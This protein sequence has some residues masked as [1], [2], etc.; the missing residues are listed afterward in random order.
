LRFRYSTEDNGRL[1]KKA[2]VYTQDEHR[3]NFSD[4]DNQAVYIIERLQ[5]NGYETYIVGGAVRDLILGKKPKDFDIVTEASPA[6]IKRVFRNSRIIGRRFR[7]VHVFFGAKIFEVSTF[8]SLKDGP[9]SNTFG[10]VD[11]DV[12]RRDFSLNALFYDPLKQIVVDYVGGMKDIRKRLIRPIIPLAHIFTDDPVRMIRAVK[13]G[14]VTGFKLPLSLKWRIRGQSNLLAGISPSRLTEEIFKII[15]SPHAFEIVQGLDALGLYSY[16]QP[17]AA[18]LFK[19]R[20]GFRA[21]YLKTMT[22]LNREDSRTL[23]GESLSALIKDYLEDIVDWKGEHEEP[24]ESGTASQNGSVLQSYKN[25]FALARK[26]ILPMNPPRME[27]EAALKLLF[28][29]HSVSI[30]KTRFNERPSRKPKLGVAHNVR[31]GGSASRQATAGADGKSSGAA[32][33][34]T[35]SGLEKHGSLPA[36]AAEGAAVK[37]RRRRRKK[38]EIRPLE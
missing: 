8:R 19:T 30:K 16:L 1:I 35:A 23:P 3:I 11:D 28:A 4:V 38:K 21:S 31:S 26:F 5:A 7:L 17:C 6:K 33:S 20:A 9:T 2:I 25:A 37:R 24:A 36:N 32:S 34:G 15:N 27:L 14:A 10:T 29:A 22:S 18:G 12:L 13:Y